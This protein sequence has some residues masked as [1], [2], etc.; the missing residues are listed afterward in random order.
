[1]KFEYIPKKDAINWSGYIVNEDKFYRFVDEF[2]IIGV[3][4]SQPQTISASYFLRL[5]QN[6]SSE[7]AR[8]YG[9]RSLENDEYSNQLQPYYMPL[10]EHGALWKKRDGSV[11]C[12]A[13]PY[14]DKESVTV[15]FN[16]MVKEFGFP[17]TIK[18]EFLDNRYR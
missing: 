10:F 2:N 5:L 13:M 8:G 14:G 9:R 17:E 16:K 18:M 15:S 7:K 11:I 6:G 12:T 3:V 4:W 1:M